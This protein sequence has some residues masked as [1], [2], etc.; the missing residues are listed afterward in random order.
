ME[1]VAR[2]EM[3]DTYAKYF[4]YLNIFMVWMWRLGLGGIINIAPKSIGQMMVLVNTG[5]KSGKQRYTPLNF[6]MI[7]DDVYCMAGFGSQ[8]QW[9]KNVLA[10]PQVEVWLPDGWWAGEIAEVTDSD[11]RVEILRAI[12][13][14]SGF[15][16][17]LLEGI[18]PDKLSDDDLEELLHQHDYRLL[19]I[20]R[21][22]TCCGVDGPGEYTWIWTLTAFWLLFR[23]LRGKK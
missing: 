18:H 8:A 19:K 9:Y 11:N 4:K 5:R 6:A 10:K 7:D 1:N 21:V 15:A 2:Q 23:L 16:A 13:I 14:A 22:A 12:L 20:K 3:L 17:P